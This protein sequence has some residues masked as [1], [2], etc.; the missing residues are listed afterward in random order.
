MNVC[1][2]FRCSALHIKKAL[3]IFRELITITRKT[4]TRVAFWDQSSG[5]KNSSVKHEFTQNLLTAVSPY[6]AEHTA[7]TKAEQ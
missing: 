4:T 7:N 3:G 2:K 5:S 1:A 6:K